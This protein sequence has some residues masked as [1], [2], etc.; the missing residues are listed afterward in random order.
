MRINVLGHGVMGAQV[1]GLMQALGHEICVW[2]RT[3]SDEKIKRQSQV[4][5]L[6]RR[7]LALSGEGG[8][9]EI[10]HTLS[11]LTPALTI[12][13]LPESPEIK[14]AVM[15]QLRYDTSDVEFFTNTSSLAPASLSSTAIGMHF[16][17]PIHVV[18]LIELSCPIVSLGPLGQQLV[19]E[20]RGA[21]YEIVSVRPNPGYVA[22][23]MLFHDISAA[24]KLLDRYGYDADVIDQIWK[25]LG[26][27]T[28]VFD[29]IDL[30]GVDVVRDILS[31]LS[32]IDAGFYVSPLLTQAIGRDIL[33]RKNRTSIRNV[34]GSDTAGNASRFV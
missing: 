12:E 22:N 23:F 32:E 20:L 11:T 9:C 26:H 21:G 4:V 8:R 6:L 5:K 29:L 25:K 34:F 7:A 13:S 18:R 16:F 24:L 33:G 1:A 19:S 15:S 17:N 31:R 28:S 14:R 2:T 27:E 30:I 10:V 3:A